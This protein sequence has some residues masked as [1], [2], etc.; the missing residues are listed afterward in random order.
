MKNKGRYCVIGV[1]SGTSLDGLDLALI[2][3]VLDNKKW[4]YQLISTATKSYTEQWKQM[5]TEARLMKPEQLALLDLNYTNFLAEQIQLFIN[6]NSDHT[7]DLISSHGHT[8]FHQPEQGLTFQIGNQKQLA[9]LLQHRVVCDFRVQDVALGG[10]GAPLVPG[11]EFHLFSEYAACVN[12]G[13]FANISLLG[14]FSPIAFD[15]AA[16]NLIFNFYAHKLNLAYDA[17]GAIASKGKIVKPLLDELDALSFYNESPPKS[18]GVEWLAQ[19]VT[20]LLSSYE[21]ESIPDL[22]H[23]YASHLATQILKVLPDS[24]K[25]LF[26]GGGT[27][28]TFLMQ[29]IQDKCSAQICI[30]SDTIIDFKEAMVFGFLGLLRSLGQHNCF[31]SVTGSSRDHSSGV[32][33]E[34]F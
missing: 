16:A 18:L 7:I 5:L 30:P 10:Q 20:P 24:G 9:D 22:M 8:V 11:G 12:L 27:H 34:I 21:Q 4:E 29:L 3:F 14:D 13:G 26:T 32:I 23:T 2:E 15:I 28:N 17:G 33:F 1:M 19:N 25:I 6:E 31:A